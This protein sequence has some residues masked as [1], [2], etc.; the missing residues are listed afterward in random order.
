[1][2]SMG[3]WRIVGRQGTQGGVRGVGKMR[4]EPPG[5]ER[6]GEVW[7]G[8]RTKEAWG[9]VRMSAEFIYVRPSG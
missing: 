6:G 9:S 3:A 7:A 4:G 5:G 1:M 8:N 2:T